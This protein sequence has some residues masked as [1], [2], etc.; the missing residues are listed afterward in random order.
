MSNALSCCQPIGH[1]R[2]SG[3]AYWR[4][5]SAARRFNSE[6]P[7]RYS[8]LSGV[9]SPLAAH[10]IFRNATQQVHREQTPANY[11]VP[12]VRAGVGVRI[13]HHRKEKSHL[14]RSL[15]EEVSWRFLQILCQGQPRQ[16][17]ECIAASPVWIIFPSGFCTEKKKLVL[18]LFPAQ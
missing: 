9:N 2:I 1:G 5:T 16:M 17:R 15:S 3:P 13:R 4:H 11:I 12:G 6:W 10:S 7:R 14:M 8:V 18:S